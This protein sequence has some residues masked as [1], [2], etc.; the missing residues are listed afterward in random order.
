[1]GR[2]LVH[3]CCAPDAVYFLK[4]L[5]ED[6]PDEEI[7]G[8]FYDPNIHPYEEY[9]LRYQETERT[10]RQL[11]IKLIEGEYDVERWLRSVKGLEDEP[12]RGK[13]CS[14]C[15]DF[16]LERSAQVA[17]ELGCDAMTT[18][19]LMSPKKSIPQLKESGEKV[20]KA[21]GVKFLTP[22]YRKGGGTQEMFRLSR[23]LELYQQDYCG[24]I[25]GLFK[26]KEGEIFWDLVS[27]RGRRPGS[28]EE[29]LF[30]KEVRTFAESL[31]LPVREFE[32]PFLSWKVLEGGIWVNR[33]PV[34][35][36]VVPFSQ[37]VR[38]KVRA[39]VERRVG[40]TLYLNKQFIRLVLV[41]DLKDRP[42]EEI[43]G[44]TSPTFLVPEHVMEKLL[45]NRVEVT[46]RT[47][48]MQERSRVLLIG[49]DDAKRLIGIPADTLQDGRGV[50][51]DQV[52]GLV[53]ENLERIKRG[54]VSLVLMGAQSLGRPGQRF[55]EEIT[56]RKVDEVL[57]Y[58]P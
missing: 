41:K 32:F 17:R 35:S 57:S 29:T 13:R 50:S 23:D 51:G 22:D 20:A 55:F 47:E 56:G 39:D 18:T 3:I 46:L 1:M 34:P 48:F 7:I 15:F 40:N 52:R 28:K 49:R 54:E 24:C 58:P 19:L 9:R 45:T 12:E 53:R 2:I 8:F 44:V 11:G 10:C 37:S 27:F 30:V 43:T 4:R 14:V 25:Y 5:R 33:E 6:F 21:Y 38:G 16:R 42:L 31:S 36:I 26:Q